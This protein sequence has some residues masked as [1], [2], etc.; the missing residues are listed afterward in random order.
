LCSTE[1]STKFLEICHA[2]C[3]GWQVGIDGG[4]GNGSLVEL[5]VE[6]MAE[7]QWPEYI[8]SAS[9]A[10]W[11]LAAMHN[12]LTNFS[13]KDVENAETSAIAAE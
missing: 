12:R 5:K 8:K 4:G 1:E 10:G 2:F 6:H 7:L 9:A 13:V 11:N 3:D